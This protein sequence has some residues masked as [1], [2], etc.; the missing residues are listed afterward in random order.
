MSDAATPLRIA[1][2]IFEGI[3]PFHLAVPCVVFAQLHPGV[4]PF[5]FRVFGAQAGT[6]RSSAGLSIEA[7]HGLE[8]LAW[9]DWVI[10]PSWPE[11]LPPVPEALRLGLRQA[12]G[13][14]AFLMG[15]CLGAFALADAGLLQGL[16]ATT[17]W[18]HAAELA[19]R[20]PEVHWNSAALHIGQPGLITSAGTAAALDCCLHMVRQQCGATVANR[21]ARRLVVAP[22]RQGDQSQFM[23][24][25]ASPEGRDAHLTQLIR[26]WQQQLHEP[27]TLASM[28]AQAHW[29]VRQFARRFRAATGRAPAQW[30]LDQRLLQA[31]HWLEH[32]RAD[33]QTIA[34]QVGFTSAVTFR[35]QFR[36]RFGMAPSRWRQQ[37]FS[38]HT[39]ASTDAPSDQPGT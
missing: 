7:A 10:V 21:L 28:A 39:E 8:A 38:A 24:I 34:Q 11:A 3:S 6:F 22:L 25:P 36:R 35:E 14:G 16:S 19:Q 31:Q 13:R 37:F 9:A 18:A 2:L 1:T 15:L 33:V 27:L 4:P 32:S 12:H 29:S 30:L 26:R 20:F 23:D 5:E 17:H